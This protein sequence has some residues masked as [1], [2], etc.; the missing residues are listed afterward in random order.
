MKM[1]KEKFDAHQNKQT[2]NVAMGLDA[3]AGKRVCRVRDG[4]SGTGKA[5]LSER[6]VTLINKRWEAVVE[7]KTGFKTYAE[8]RASINEELGRRLATPTLK[9]APKVQCI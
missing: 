3:D 8:M 7:K 9:S 2:Y 6:V 4:K 5:S 1:H